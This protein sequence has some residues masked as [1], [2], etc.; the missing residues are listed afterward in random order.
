MVDTVDD[1][2]ELRRSRTTDS[3]RQLNR[4]RGSRCMS[5][6]GR[7]WVAT[8]QVPGHRQKQRHVPRDW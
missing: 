3:L 1:A 6:L 8:G 2:P 7:L 4:Y 5:P